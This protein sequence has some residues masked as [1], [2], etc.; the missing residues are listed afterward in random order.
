M[1]NRLAVDR[2]GWIKTPISEEK[3]RIR[4]K[5]SQYYGRWNRW[6]HTGGGSININTDFS[7][8]IIIAVRPDGSDSL[9]TT[10]TNREEETL[11]FALDWAERS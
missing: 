1:T 11:Q 7:Y 4:Q 9:L 6:E 5:L 3:H 2:P 10:L 8:N